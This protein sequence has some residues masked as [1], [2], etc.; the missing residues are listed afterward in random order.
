MKFRGMVDNVERLFP[1]Y[2]A[3]CA[4]G[5]DG[6]SESRGMCHM[7]SVGTT[8]CFSVGCDGQFKPQ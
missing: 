7:L 4:C 2:T 1:E 6:R 8:M 3:R 5:A